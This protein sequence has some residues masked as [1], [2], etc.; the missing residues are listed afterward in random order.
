M[1]PATSTEYAGTMAQVLGTL[2]IALVLEARFLQG[3]GI[4]NR[5]HTALANLIGATGLIIAVVKVGQTVEGATR[6]LIELLTIL[7]VGNVAGMFLVPYLFVLRE[8]LGD[9]D[10]LRWSGRV[11]TL[12]VSA[13][14][15]GLAFFVVVAAWQSDGIAKLL[16]TL[17]LFVAC[18][19]LG[20]S[21]LY[22]QDGRR[23]AQNEHARLACGE[24]DN[25]SP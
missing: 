14:V 11:K 16:V 10:R 6:T 19:V 12:A 24:H 23:V 13:T 17:A 4:V 2:L 3:S 5:A 9:K 15:L 1:N 25:Q 22:M 8:W 21:G 18:F 7:T 20:L